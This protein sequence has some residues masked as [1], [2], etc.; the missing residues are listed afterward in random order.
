MTPLTL[1]DAATI[2]CP[3][4]YA[5]L[6]ASPHGLSSEQVA[7]RLA[8]FGA[9]SLGERK[10]Q[11][12]V[13]LGRQVR[14]PL[15]ILLVVT[16]LASV[17]LGE[18]TDAAIILVIIVMSVGLGFVNEYR[19][20]RAMI[21]LTKRV[22]HRAIVLRDGRT[23]DVDVAMLVPGDIVLLAVGDIVPADMRLCETDEL[24]CD[25]AVLTGESLPAEKTPGAVSAQA[26]MSA[27]C[28]AL[29][30][31][32]VKS[33]SAKGIVIATGT[34]TAFGTI[35]ARLAEHPP[36]TAFQAGLAQFS[37]LLVRVAAV[38]TISIFVVNSALHHALLESLLF[39]LAIAVGLT[40]QLLPAIVTVSLAT[41]A[42][43]LARRA[44]IVKRLVSIEDL[45]NIDVLFTDKTGTLTE[46]S[47]AFRASLDAQG[48]ASGEIFRLGLLCTDAAI[49]NGD[50]IGGTALDRALWEHA[51]AAGVHPNGTVRIAEA[52]FDYERKRMS[53]AVQD[54]SGKR[55]MI[56][57]G[58][59]EAV[60]A[61]CVHVDPHAQAIVDD[62]FSTGQRVIAIA[63]RDDVLGDTLQPSD[64]RD[65]RFRGFICFADPV[66]AD[67]A[68]SI[69]RLRRLDVDVRIITGDNEKV[70]VKVCSELGIPVEETRSGSALESMSDAELKEA[71]PRTTIF[72]RV[73]PDQKSRIIRLQRELGSDVGFLGDGVNDAVALHYADVG[74]SVDSG[75]DVAKDAADVVLLHKDL[76]VL[77]DGVVE[78]RRIFSNT[79]KYVLMGTSSNFGNM[80]SAAGASLFLPFL[81]MTAS[82][83]L[84]N[85]LLYDV[86][87]MT[88]PTDR[89]DEELLRRPSHW[90]IG[91]IRR[92]MLVFGPISSIFDFMTYGIMLFVFHAGAALFRSGWFVESLLT[93]SLIIFVIRTQRVPFFRSMPSPALLV[94]TLCCVIVGAV[95]PFSPIAGFFGFVPLPL[96]FFGILLAMIAAYLLLVEAAKGLFFRPRRTLPSSA[97]LRRTRR[98]GRLASRFVGKEAP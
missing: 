10:V 46:G 93:Q 23:C 1:Q 84:L 58:A 90:D 3:D 30:G 50:I 74:I 91:F 15:L 54:A 88:I 89:V 76:G 40:P 80:F 21:D 64:E 41:G 94:T 11:A 60:L 39:S 59:P 71:L 25:E 78:G 56:T 95:L 33:G 98:L 51:L 65:L 97:D 32:T 5:R 83:I 55:S 36:Q 79:I 52:P 70:A 73:T 7:E 18:H 31:T 16:A 85:N 43:R 69:E 87:E 47:I 48:Q 75:T 44:V 62:L 38:L 22:R 28:C 24:T 63:T 66:K 27:P 19:S 42:E 49:S 26:A 92:F 86:S 17:F 53:V 12:F 35:A 2:E 4:V 67:A 9:N 68:Q 8:V 61:R 29:M 82:Q 14:N 77:A 6:E 96:L 81:P 72:A 20:E 37:G 34:T 45:G 57:K 13:V